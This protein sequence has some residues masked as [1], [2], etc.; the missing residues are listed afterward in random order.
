[1]D[2]DDIYVAHAPY[3][4]VSLSRLVHESL[5]SRCTICHK[6]GKLIIFNLNVLEVSAG[7]D[8]LD[9]SCWKSHGPLHAR[10]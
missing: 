2:L 7:F 10:G 9:R 8:N 3:D 4:I 1:M 5:K 6:I